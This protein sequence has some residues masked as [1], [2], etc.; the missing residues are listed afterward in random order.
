MDTLMLACCPNASREDGPSHFVFKLTRDFALN[1]AKWAE[2]HRQAQVVAETEVYC[3]E[4]F[5]SAG[6]WGTVSGLHIDQMNQDWVRVAAHATAKSEESV[7]LESVKVMSDG[8]V[9]SALWKNDDI[10][11]YFETPPLSMKVI[12]LVAACS[13]VPDD[14]LP[15]A[16]IDDEEDD[17]EDTSL[18]EDD[19]HQ[20]CERCGT[21]VADGYC[22]D[23]T[24][25]FSDHKQNCPAGWAN[26]PT[27]PADSKC[28]CG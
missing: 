2:A 11:G 15:T 23:Q 22:T 14:L 25:P 16:E 8:V 20:E 3:V 17:E 4:I 12:N 10:G 5:C 27:Q 21:R 26:H 28:T 1:L 6:E 24:C 19:E 13:P 7:E 9:F 18:Y